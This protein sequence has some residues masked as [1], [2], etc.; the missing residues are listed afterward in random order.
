MTD[1]TTHPLLAR[2]DDLLS[3]ADARVVRP[4]IPAGNPRHDVYGPKPANRA[5]LQDMLGAQH[6]KVK[7]DDALPE[8]HITYTIGELG[9]VL[10]RKAGTIRGWIRAGTI[11]EADHWSE[12]EAGAAKR[13]FTKRQV[14][15]LLAIAQSEGI[16]GKDRCDIVKTG[17]SAR[18]H[19]LWDDLRER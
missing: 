4:Q 16:L 13:L 14:F 10:G 6:F 7:P 17:F 2:L 11:P 1:P 5:S 12:G 9:K 15:G 3:G 18:A 19:D 8:D